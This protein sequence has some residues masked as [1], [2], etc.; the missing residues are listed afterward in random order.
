MVGKAEAELLQ[1]GFLPTSGFGDATQTALMAVGGGQD[2]V[3][4]LQ[5]RQ[6]SKSLHDGQWLRVV[7]SAYQCLWNDRGSTFQ[8]ML[9][10]DPQRI[11]QE[12]DHDVSLHARLELMEIRV[13]WTARF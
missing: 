9:E 4:A 10:R 5:S 1:K 6:Q 3:G 7:D 2:D 12:R 13:G 8:Q 11:A